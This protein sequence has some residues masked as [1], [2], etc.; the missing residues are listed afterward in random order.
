M[1]RRS[2]ARARHKRRLA[3]GADRDTS[4]LTQPSDTPKGRATSACRRFSWTTA[5]IIRRARDMPDAGDQQLP[6]VLR[7]AFPMS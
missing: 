6:Y 5:M 2:F 1:L 3:F 4:L 7:H